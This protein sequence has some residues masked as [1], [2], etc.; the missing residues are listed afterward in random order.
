[1]NGITVGQVDVSKDRW[2]FAGRHYMVT[3]TSSAEDM[4]L[5]LEDVGPGVGRGF[6]AIANK[7]DDSEEITVSTLTADP[8]PAELVTQF[9]GEA[10]NRL[11]S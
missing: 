8:L 1:M 6:V 7:L 2:F 5:E 10:C 9:I 4:S 11:P 3:L